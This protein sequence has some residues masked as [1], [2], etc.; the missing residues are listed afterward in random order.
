MNKIEV[1]IGQL[2]DEEFISGGRWHIIFNAEI[3]VYED[4]VPCPHCGPITT[5]EHVNVYGSTYEKKHMTCPRTVD[6]VLC[7]DC[8]L[9]AVKDL[10]VDV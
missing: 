6:G 2:V 1:P 7:L 3:P 5:S 10:E 9:D 4:T 8:I